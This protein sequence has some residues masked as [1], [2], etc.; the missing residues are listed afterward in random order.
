MKTFKNIKTFFSTVFLAGIF[1][2]SGC[3]GAEGVID[4]P[5]SE[6]NNKPA[7]RPLP[8]EGF[9]LKQLSFYYAG[10]ESKINLVSP[11]VNHTTGDYTVAD[12]ELSHGTI[13]AA[14][15]A[16]DEN[17]TV[18]ISWELGGRK[19]AMAEAVK[20]P[21]TLDGIAIP[22]PAA[23]S[24]KN[25]LVTVTVTNARKSYNYLVT[26]KAPG[27][28]ASLA[29]LAV[30][31]ELDIGKRNLEGE[32]SAGNPNNGTLLTGDGKYFSTARYEYT[33]ELSV[34]D[35][36]ANA[37]L[38]FTT[39]PNSNGS[40]I[41]LTNTEEFGAEEIPVDDLP[42][43]AAQPSSTQMSVY[44]NDVEAAGGEDAETPTPAAE[45]PKPAEYQYWKVPIPP[46]GS[47]AIKVNFEVTN[48]GISSNYTVTIVPPPDEEA[49]TD[50]TL[51]NLQ[52]K[53]SDSGAYLINFTPTTTSYS[54]RVLAGQKTAEIENCAPTYK[55]AVV[56]VTI[57]NGNPFNYAEATETKKKFNLPAYG[58]ELV[59][60]FKVTAGEEQYSQ[61]YTVTFSNPKTA[62]TWKGTVSLEGN[63]GT[64]AYKVTNVE[65]TTSGGQTF[66]ANVTGD[67]NAWSVSIDQETAND[68]NPPVSFVV[69]LG[70]PKSSDANAKLT[71]Y[72]VT[73][74]PPSTPKSN[75]A[76]AL[77]YDVSNSGSGDP[78]YLVVYSPNDLAEMKPGENYYLANDIDLTTLPD[79]WDGPNNYAG[80]FNGNGKTIKLQLSNGNKD[81]GLFDS[82][83]DGVVIENLKVQVST[84][85][86]GIGITGAIFFGAVVGGIRGNGG[87]YTIRNV[88]V[89]GEL[90][91]RSV[92]ASNYLLAGGIMGQAYKSDSVKAIN[93]LIENCESDLDIIADL[94]N[95]GGSF[96]V[97]IGGIIGKFGDNAGSVTIKNC[98]TGG[99]IKETVYGAGYTIRVGGIIATSEGGGDFEGDSSPV[100]GQLNISNCYSTTEIVAYKNNDSATTV[101]V[102]G[103]LA[104]FLNNTNAKIENSIALNTSVTAAVKSGTAY[105]VGRVAG[106]VYPALDATNAGGRLVNNYAL[107][108]MPVG[109]SLN[110]DGVPVTAPVESG[111]ANDTNGAPATPNQ[112]RDRAFWTETLGFSE[113]DWDFSGLSNGQYPA[114]KLKKN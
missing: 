79:D 54:Y 100:S 78:L 3:Q 98:R 103:G 27:T 68:E 44:K 13:T 32:D 112:L 6:V 106:L 48:S 49:E 53:D 30:V 19:G 28:D 82:I 107:A 2:L 51:M 42:E 15:E 89:T 110:K 50:S 47:A 90:K 12:A 63:T 72:R 59:V 81:T 31:Y 38:I 5:Q 9:F 46:K 84:I 104:G 92:S 69:M 56:T 7:A 41:T 39:Y 34:E 23:K 102:A 37:N 74:T 33:V 8:S 111:V 97:A 87:D 71:P 60:K 85:E 88:S 108:T 94:N 113:S 73:V 83:A 76:I 55:D 1:M 52:I 93:L 35:V 95:T 80:K 40:T 101:S 65:V 17:A 86:D 61:E 109:T 21:A 11:Q 62:L 77:S 22:E 67:N 58:S 66:T 114:L 26:I 91:Y 10:D 70:E 45:Q 24:Q 18:L 75:V 105:H 14:A 4:I 96:V 57:G 36:G 64:P 20:G 16:E 29:Y 43:P 25:T 99:S